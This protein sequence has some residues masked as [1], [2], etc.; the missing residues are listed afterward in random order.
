[1]AAATVA[2]VYAQAL[3][4]VADEHGARVV[5]VE[6]CRELARVLAAHSDLLTSVQ[7][8]RVGKVRAKQAL[9]AALSASIRSEL[10]TLVLV[11]VDRNRLSDLPAILGE[12]VR[13]AEVD[14]GVVHVTATT[15]SDLSGGARNQLASALATAIGPGVVLHTATDPALLGGVTLRIGDTYVDGSVRRQLSEMK[16]VM[17]SVPVDGRLWQE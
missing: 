12:A 7:D 2:A 9:T 17:L 16:S 13:R 3:L 8:P 5:V 6:D 15:A 14:A 4:E 10:M 1:M 11:L